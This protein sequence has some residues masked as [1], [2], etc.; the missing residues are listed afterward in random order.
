MDHCIC[1]S[2]G[3]SQEFHGSSSFKLGGTEQGNSVSGAICRDTL[4]LIF[5]K[6]EDTQLGIKVILPFSKLLFLRSVI[7]FVDDIDFCTNDK[8]FAIK[9]Q[10]VMNLCAWLHEAI[11]VKM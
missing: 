10:L 4:C 7:V 6:L 2:Y 5:N 8:D 1:T 9:M 3:K 11:G